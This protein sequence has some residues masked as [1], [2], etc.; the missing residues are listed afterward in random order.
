MNI[1][2]PVQKPG[3]VVNEEDVTKAMVTIRFKRY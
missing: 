3:R 1:S 2:F